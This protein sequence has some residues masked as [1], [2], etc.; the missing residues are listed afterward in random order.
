MA[1]SSDRQKPA[2]AAPQPV[3]DSVKTKKKSRAKY[4]TTTAAAPTSAAGAGCASE[5]FGGDLRDSGKMSTEPVILHLKCFLKDLVE[6][7]VE[8]MK[9]IPTTS[10]FT[11]YTPTVPPDVTAYDKQDDSPPFRHPNY[12]FLASASASAPGGR[13]ADDGANDGGERPL[14]WNFGVERERSTLEPLGAA[15]GG[16]LEMLRTAPL[17]VCG[18]SGLESEREREPTGANQMH[19]SKTGACAWRDFGGVEST[20]AVEVSAEVLGAKLKALKINMYKNVL[21]DKAAAC[22]WCTYD[23]D[24]PACFLPK[25]DIDRSVHVYGCFCSPECAAGY[26]MSE[27]I[28]DS[29][30]FERYQLLNQMYAKLYGHDYNIPLAPKPQYLL[31][32]FFGNLTVDEYRALSRLHKRVVVLDR[33]MTRVLPEIHEDLNDACVAGAQVWAGCGG[34][35]G[36]A[37]LSSSA[38]AAASALSARTFQGYGNYRVKRQDDVT[39]KVCKN[40]ILRETFGISI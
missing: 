39:T 26:L 40:T 9:M 16:E 2:V 24:T 20:K 4:T 38:A 37:A 35:A 18:E 14:E 11:T 12:S 23:F 5:S 19:Y 17:R 13:S 29:A 30:K 34:A 36:A 7:D 33:P 32:K 22:F 27:P 28:D 25:H 15:G 6:R 3:V 21:L 31:D 1:P 10:T 8:L